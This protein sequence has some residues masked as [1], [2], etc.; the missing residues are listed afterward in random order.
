[1]KN[2]FF[3]KN[4]FSFLLSC[5]VLFE[6]CPIECIISLKIEVKGKVNQKKLQDSEQ[7]VGFLLQTQPVLPYFDS[8]FF[9]LWD[10][11]WFIEE[12]RRE[13]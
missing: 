4:R 6:H 5:D 1:M 8:V 7:N 12:A 9:L 10:F 2:I 11:I 13:Q 3:L